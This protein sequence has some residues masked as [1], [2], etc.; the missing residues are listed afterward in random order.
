MPAMT[1]P[2]AAT[3]PASP[4]VLADRLITLAE[5]AD[6]AGF[7]RTASRLVRLACKVMEEKPGPT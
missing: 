3:P 4:L 1:V 5:D 7:A 6:R 2:A